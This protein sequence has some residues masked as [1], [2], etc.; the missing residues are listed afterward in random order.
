MADLLSAM[1]RALTYAENVLE[2]VH[3][4]QLGDPTPCTE[5]SV[6]ALVDHVVGAS[7]FVLR[8]VQDRPADPAGSDTAAADT[9]AAD[10]A[11]ADTAAADPMAGEPPAAVFRAR[12]E[13]LRAL[14]TPAMLT[15][16]FDSPFGPI[17]G[18]QLAAITVVEAV[19]HGLDLALATGQA[20]R[21]DDSLGEVAVRL[22]EAMGEFGP[23]DPNMIG[24]AVPVSAD[25]P[26]WARF[27]GLIGRDPAWSPPA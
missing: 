11:G 25:A 16:T 4:R 2:T 21:P 8:I 18:S 15:R 23:R 24:P 20:Q 6:Q 22:A 10:T 5:F 1:D 9:A 12:A 14:C 17:P 3:E 19:G 7:Q 13:A 26:A 27:Y